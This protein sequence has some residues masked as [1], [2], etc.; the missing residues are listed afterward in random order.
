[1]RLEHNTISTST[2]AGNKNTHGKVVAEFV[3]S[4]ISVPSDTS[5]G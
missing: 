3:P 2:P 4:A 1:M 5:G